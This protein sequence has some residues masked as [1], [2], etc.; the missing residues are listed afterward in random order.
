MVSVKLRNKKGKREILKER[1]RARQHRLKSC[2]G[3]DDDDDED[4]K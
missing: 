1:Y 3:D 2:V 4:D